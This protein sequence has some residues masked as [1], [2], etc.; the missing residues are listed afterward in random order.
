MA[1][2]SARELVTR[3]KR[4]VSQGTSK[5][6]LFPDSREVAVDKL[7]KDVAW[8]LMYHPFCAVP[9]SRGI[10]VPYELSFIYYSFEYDTIYGRHIES[11][12]DESEARRYVNEMKQVGVHGIIHLGVDY[13]LYMQHRN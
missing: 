13:E 7:D 5:R 10:A 12:R 11:Y 4:A 9:D 6:V 8:E 2:I 1:T 3:Y